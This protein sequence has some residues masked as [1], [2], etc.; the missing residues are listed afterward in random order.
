MGEQKQ[1]DRTGMVLQDLSDDELAKKGE[2]LAGEVKDREN[3]LEKKR[4]HNREWNEQIRQIDER[5]N[6]LAEEVDSG[7]A[8]VSAQGGL[9]DK[10]PAAKANGNGKPAAK[11]ASK[12]AKKAAPKGKA[13]SKGARA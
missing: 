6:V 10:K 11:G 8:W 1:P 7:Q 3:L 4:S 9:F 5:V 2:Q 12:P 13:K